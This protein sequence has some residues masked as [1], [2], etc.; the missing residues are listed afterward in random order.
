MHTRMLPPLSAGGVITSPAILSSSPHC[1]QHHQFNNKDKRASARTRLTVAWAQLLLI[2]AAVVIASCAHSSW[3][4]ISVLVH[5]DL[6]DHCFDDR[7]GEAEFFGAKRSRLNKHATPRSLWNRFSRG[8]FKALL[9]GSANCGQKFHLTPVP[10]L[11][12]SL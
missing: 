12:N 1:T 11:C 4:H 9:I 5:L 8:S 6:P 3:T 7:H 2:I 10:P